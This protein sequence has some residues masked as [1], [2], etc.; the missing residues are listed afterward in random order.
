MIEKFLLDTYE[1]IEIRKVLSGNP[2]KSKRVI[3]KSPKWSFNSFSLHNSVF[4]CTSSVILLYVLIICLMEF[5]MEW[6]SDLVTIS[7]FQVLIFVLRSK[8]SS[9]IPQS[10]WRPFQVCTILK[11]YEV[12][13]KC[14][15]F[16]RVQ[17]TSA[18]DFYY[19]LYWM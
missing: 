18:N 15:I 2:Q 5:A 16:P 7:C 4:H 3:S 11:C 9:W 6:F 17:S 8:R 14:S 19:T 12:F 13:T 1:N 10:P